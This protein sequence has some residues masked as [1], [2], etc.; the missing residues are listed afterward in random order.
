M[1]ILLSN[2]CDQW[3]KTV[4][5]KL[6]FT[7]NYLFISPD[8]NMTQYL[9]SHQFIPRKWFWEISTHNFGSD[10]VLVCYL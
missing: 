5:A 4:P 10:S 3:Q 7:I 8:I 2:Q 9:K 6:K 1:I